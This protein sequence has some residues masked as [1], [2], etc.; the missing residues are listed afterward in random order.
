[1]KNRIKGLALVFGLLSAFIAGLSFYRLKKPVDGILSIPKLLGSTFAPFWAVMGFVGAVLGFIARAPFAVIAGVFGA[2]VS[3]S[4]V[5]DVAAP[6][7]GFERAFGVNWAQSVLPE[8]KKMMLDRR[9]RWKLP[10][11]PN[12]RWVR[13]VWDVVRFSHYQCATCY[14]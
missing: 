4:Y 5:R 2:F 12:P 7:D 11:A 1:M 9:W 10:T 14:R 8:Q 3:A 6:H 13:D